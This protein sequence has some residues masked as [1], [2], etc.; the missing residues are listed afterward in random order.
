MRG[1]RAGAI[2]ALVSGAL[3]VGFMAAAGQLRAL[4]PAAA[5]FTATVVL[6]GVV[7]DRLL[8]SGRMRYGYGP[9]IVFWIV[10]FPLVRLVQ[11]LVSAVAGAETMLGEGPVGFVVWQTLVGGAFGLGFVLLH[12]QVWQYLER[13]R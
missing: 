3:M 9:A 6:A 8:D 12:Q 4:L 13:P 2:T 1:G 11:E 10:A 5:A 7:F